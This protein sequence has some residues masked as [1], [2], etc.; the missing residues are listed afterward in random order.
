M[1]QIKVKALY[2]SN[3]QSIADDVNNETLRIMDEGNGLVR[4]F[5]PSNE[6][7]KSTTIILE[8]LDLVST[9]AVQDALKNGHGW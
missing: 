6:V 9:S 3:Y 7:G 2:Y 1:S 4:I 5:V 8:A